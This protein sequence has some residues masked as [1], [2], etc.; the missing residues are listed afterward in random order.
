MIL[1]KV[2]CPL[3]Q[4]NLKLEFEDE[5]RSVKSKD[6]TFEDS[7]FEFDDDAFDEG[8]F[9]IQCTGECTAEFEIE[10]ENHIIFY[11][12]EGSA[13]G[14]FEDNEWAEIDG[15]KWITEGEIVYV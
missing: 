8:P 14:I 11:D 13:A 4:S 5:H 7:V 6:F 15:N 2:K 9:V 12:S 10:D 1:K 3:C